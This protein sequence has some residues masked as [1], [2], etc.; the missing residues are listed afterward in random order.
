MIRDQSS[1]EVEHR[2]ILN[3]TSSKSSKKSFAEVLAS[4]PPVG[5]DEN[6]GRVEDEYKEEHVFRTLMSSARRE[7]A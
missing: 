3:E 6:F 7:N 5:Q 1:A 4:M 2:A